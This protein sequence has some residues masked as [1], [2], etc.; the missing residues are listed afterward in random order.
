MP[1]RASARRWFARMR[2]QRIAVAV[3]AGMFA[4]RRNEPLTPGGYGLCRVAGGLI[5]LIA[6]YAMGRLDQLGADSYISVGPYFMIVVGIA[7]AVLP[8][9]VK[10]APSSPPSTAQPR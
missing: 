9:V 7:V 2:Q 10:G 6:I 4:G 1:F 3:T 8:N 5:A